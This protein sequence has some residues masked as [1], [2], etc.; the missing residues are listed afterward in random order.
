MRGLINEE[1][2]K[3]L[4]QRNEKGVQKR[5]EI[6]AILQM[7]QT[8]VTD[9]ALRVER[10]FENVNPQTHLNTIIPNFLKEIEGI[11]IYANEQLLEIAKTYKSAAIVL[12]PNMRLGSL[13]D[14]EE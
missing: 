4:L 6:R 9:T 12:R 7:V 1:K 3:T 5:R 11:R 8:I 14:L 2:F 13:K 10:K